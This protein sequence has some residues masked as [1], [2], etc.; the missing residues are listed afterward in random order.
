MDP[1]ADNLVRVIDRWSEIET[2][3]FN[4]STVL[5]KL[6]DRRHLGAI[7][8]DPDGIDTFLN[9]ITNDQFFENRPRTSELRHGMFVSGGGIQT[10]GDLHDFLTS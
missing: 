10:E 9:R 7:P 4:R 2:G 5:K 6:W 1:V 3:T 8:F